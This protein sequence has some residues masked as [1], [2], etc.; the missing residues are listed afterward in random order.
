[1]AAEWTKAPTA[2]PQATASPVPEVQV[3]TPAG[4]DKLQAGEPFN[5][6]WRTS[7]IQA[8]QVLFQRNFGR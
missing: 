1:M 8:P 4:L 5:V 3:L 2:A 6:A 7:G